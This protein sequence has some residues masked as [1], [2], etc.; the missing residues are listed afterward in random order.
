M[1]SRRSSTGTERRRRPQSR[2][3]LFPL[4]ITHGESKQLPALYT[5]SVQPGPKATFLWRH[6]AQF[7]G[8]CGRCCVIYCWLVA[9]TCSREVAAVTARRRPRSV[10]M[11]LKTL[12]SQEPVPA[13]R[14]LTPRNRCR[15][16]RPPTSVRRSKSYRFA[17]SRVLLLGV[18]RGITMA[19]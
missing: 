3:F 5:A 10:R 15:S 18:C 8:R 7:K 11:R 6:L 12:A 19:S 4:S 2:N 1:Q 13:C 17:W 16:R 14:S 9:A